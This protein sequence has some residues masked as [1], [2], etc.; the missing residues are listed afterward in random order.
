VVRNALLDMVGVEYPIFLAPLGGG[1][2]TPELAAE[3]GNAGGLAALA[4]AY[5]TPEEM[6]DGVR[7][8]R[9]LT[10]APLNVNLFAG[11]YHTQTGQDP[12]PM[13]QLIAE[14]HWELGLAVPKLP[15]LPQDPFEKQFDTLVSLK[16][17]VFSF[18]F[19]IPPRQAIERARLAGVVSIG[20]ATTVEEGRM[21]EAAG[22]DAIVAQGAEAGGQRGTFHGTFEDGLV[23][24][25]ELVTG[26]VQQ[27]R[28]PVIASGGLMNGR[29]IA[30]MLKMGASAV[31][32]GTAFLCCPEAGTST[33]YR[34]ALLEARADR[35]VITYAFTGR[36]ARGL[37]NEFMRRMASH[38]DK[39][40]PFPLQNQLTR[41]LRKAA[42]E[43]GNPE[44]LSL[45]AGTGV[46]EVR[47]QPAAEV[48]RRL[49]LETEDAL[50]GPGRI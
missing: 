43:Q 35:T 42:S 8:I 31:Q 32:L 7:R 15:E 38:R 34:K 45:W 10:Q 40:L 46:A 3:V 29:Q 12:G 23:P 21:L 24:L 30:G 28:V 13:L 50:G 36:G 44:F 26:L 39:V 17:K 14:V 49:V 19:G 9:E 11:G 1:P 48:M 33:T 5:L 37:E 6:T 20:S 4:A 25:A 18:T 47:Q 16:P 22:V 27:V 41:D 2:S